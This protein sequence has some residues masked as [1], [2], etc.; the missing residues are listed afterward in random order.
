MKKKLIL[1]GITIVL[2]MNITACRTNEPT[3]NILDN[4]NITEEINNEKETGEDK[5]KKEY[6]INEEGRIKSEY[7]KQIIEESADKLIYAISIKDSKTIS[8]LVHPVK[9]VRFTPYTHVSIEH[10]V[11]LNR[12]Q[13][14]NF[15]YDEEVYMWG[16]YDGIGDEISLTPSEYYEKFIYTNDFLNPEIVG[17]TV[18]IKVIISSTAS[19]FFIIYFF[20]NIFI[21]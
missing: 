19:F 7:A 5:E 3:D 15:F 11:V 13:I 17:Y 6:E 9:G 10:D 4:E 16:Y 14:E 2:L 18:D 8:E 21:V 1:I 12:D 20:C